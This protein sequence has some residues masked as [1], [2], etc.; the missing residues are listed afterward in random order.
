MEKQCKSM[1]QALEP[2]QSTSCNK[3]ETSKPSHFSSISCT[4]T[5]PAWMRPIRISETNQSLQHLSL[6]PQRYCMPYI[7]FLQ[8]SASWTQLKLRSKLAPVFQPPICLR[9]LQP[10]RQVIQTF[11]VVKSSSSFAWIFVGMIASG[12]Q[13]PRC[14]SF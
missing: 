8:V 11:N 6:L 5:C 12:Y 3:Y 10:T 4:N 7:I 13:V 1:D 2:E 9:P 14:S